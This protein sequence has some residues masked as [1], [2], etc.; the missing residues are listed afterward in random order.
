MIHFAKYDWVYTR[1]GELVKDVITVTREES[2]TCP[3]CRRDHGYHPAHEM[4]ERDT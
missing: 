4:P 3:K 2:A 1:C